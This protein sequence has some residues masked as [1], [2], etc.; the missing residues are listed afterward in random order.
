[1]VHKIMMM[2][3]EKA[4][5]Y[6][7]E[8]SRPILSISACL[9]TAS[10][11]MHG[12]YPLCRPVVA[13]SRTRSHF[14]QSLATFHLYKLLLESPAIIVAKSFTIPHTDPW[15]CHSALRHPEPS[16]YLP[17]SST[18]LLTPTSAL[19]RQDLPLQQPTPI[20]IEQPD[21]SPNNWHSITALNKTLP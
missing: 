9:S 19:T 17:A 21:I 7:P 16:A 4:R 12:I 2:M 15:K 18:H 8:R 3:H 6:R 5:K 10:M 13:P 20:Y 11:S 14:V 1:M